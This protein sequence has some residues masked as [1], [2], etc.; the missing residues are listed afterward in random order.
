MFYQ[1][2]KQETMEIEIGSAI[3]EDDYEELMEKLKVADLL[4]N[5]YSLEEVIYQLAK[6]MFTQSLTRV[7]MGLRYLLLQN[8]ELS[9][10]LD[11]NRCRIVAIIN[12]GVDVATTPGSAEA[13]DALQKFTSFLEFE[14]LQGRISRNLEKKVL[15]VLIASLSDTLTEH[16]ELVST[17]RESLLEPSVHSM[18]QP[19]GSSGVMK[20]QQQHRFQVPSSA[21]M[22]KQTLQN[23]GLQDQEKKSN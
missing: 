2:K 21:I 15:D 13:Q 23:S 3:T 4:Y 12:D 7:S 5:E 9:L 20:Q 1:N 19:F 8:L 11:S 18:D 14:A 17:A 16:P 6:L 10:S 22:M